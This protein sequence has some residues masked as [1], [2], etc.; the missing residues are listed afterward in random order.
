MRTGVSAGVS[1]A[2][3]SHDVV[4]GNKLSRHSASVPLCK[5]GA[6]PVARAPPS[7]AIRLN[8]LLPTPL[9]EGALFRVAERDA[10]CGLSRLAGPRSIVIESPSPGD[11]VTVAGGGASE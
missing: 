9:A 10:D 5:S 3:V 7:P 6:S 8:K 1:G 11:S 2:R 4:R